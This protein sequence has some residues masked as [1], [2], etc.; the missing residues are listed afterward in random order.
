M[1]I[2]NRRQSLFALI[3]VWRAAWKPERRS[4]LAKTPF[5]RN[6]QIGGQQKNSSRFYTTETSTYLYNNRGMQLLY[7]GFIIKYS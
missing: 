2:V 7:N 5:P 4:G 1:N 6:F 3:R